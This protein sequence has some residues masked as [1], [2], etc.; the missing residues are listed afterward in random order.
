MPYENYRAQEPLVRE[1]EW[2]ILGGMALAA[3]AGYINVI[4]L[5]FFQIPVSHMSGASSKFG[6]ALSERNLVELRLIS[7]VI[8]G[9]FLGAVVSGMAVAGSQLR[10]G[11]RYGAVLMLE[12]LVLACATWLLVHGRNAGVPLAAIACGLQNGMASSYYG[13]VIR[14][15]HVTGIVTD[16]GVITGHWLRGHAV[17]AWKVV[18][19]ASLLGGFIGGG[20]IGTAFLLRGGVKTL[21]FAS[22][23]C[24]ICGA[25]YAIWI[26][27]RRKREALP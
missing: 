19:L 22:A 13:L 7:G 4:V 9:F 5:D 6:A 1:R 20:V 2:I 23:A 11:R 14:T 25:V 16:L 17:P 15:T 8:G 10:P 26:H 3:I 27:M 12:G 24:L 18:M 21:G